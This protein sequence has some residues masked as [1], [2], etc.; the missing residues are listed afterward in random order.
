[1]TQTPAIDIRDLTVR[2]G[3]KTAL[4]GLSLS[5]GVGE[6]ITLTG[7]SGSGK[8]TVLRSLLG[9]APVR[10]GRLA[11]EGVTVTAE[12]IWKLRHRLAYVPQEPQMGQGTT[13]EV[14]AAPF[15]YRANA[16]LRDRLDRVPDLMERYQLGLDLLDKP[17]GSL[18][19]G[20]KQRVALI[21]ALLLER[22]ILLLD[23]ASS[24]LDPASKTVVAADIAAREDLTVLSIS[25]DTRGFGFG[26]RTIDIDDLTHAEATP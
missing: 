8:S 17:I 21:A 22:P 3:E 7:R 4:A 12:S 15:H 10:A 18:S 19:G 9:F 14:I 16:H 25:H 2:F 5:V 24:A 26:G 23:E 20:E 11:I 1:M 6:K 13:R